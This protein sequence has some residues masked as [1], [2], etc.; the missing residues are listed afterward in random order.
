MAKDMTEESSSRPRQV[1]SQRFSVIPLVQI[2]VA[3]VLRVV[4]SKDAAKVS[5]LLRLKTGNVAVSET[6]CSTV[7][8]L[9]RQ[10]I[11]IV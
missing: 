8:Q 10:H 1:Y 9:N 2:C 4:D 6:P 7:V 5:T 11:D 3:D